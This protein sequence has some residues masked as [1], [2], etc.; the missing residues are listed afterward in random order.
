MH[1]II[2]FLKKKSQFQIYS[3]TRKTTRSCWVSGG[4]GEGMGEQFFF[5]ILYN[6]VAVLFL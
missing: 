4:L 3:G 5:Q 6:A 1:D 2:C